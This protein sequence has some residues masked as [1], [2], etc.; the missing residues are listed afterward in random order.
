M[1]VPGKELE[2]GK[3]PGG[4]RGGGNRREST[5]RNRKQEKKKRTSKKV[6]APVCQPVAKKTRMGRIVGSNQT[7]DHRN[8]ETRENLQKPSPHLKTIFDFPKNFFSP[9]API[10][11]KNNSKWA[12]QSGLSPPGLKNPVTTEGLPV[13]L[14][15]NFKGW[16][17]APSPKRMGGER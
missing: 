1:V 7:C 9:S 3:W 5:K 16:P 15:G 12:T 2:G 10:Q 17:Q 11:K 6:P 4:G 8:G 14:F 13:V